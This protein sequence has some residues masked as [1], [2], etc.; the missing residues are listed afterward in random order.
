[1]A[2]IGTYLG[3]T[4]VRKFRKNPTIHPPKSM[5]LAMRERSTKAK[6]GRVRFFHIPDGKMAT[7]QPIIEANVQQFPERIIT[8]LSAVYEIMFRNAKHFA[9]RTVNHSREWIVPGTRFHTN[10]MESS[11]SLLKKR[12]LIGSFHRVSVKHLHRYLTEFEYRFNARNAG[13]RF[14][15]ALSA[16]LHKPHMPYK[17]LIA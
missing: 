6:T 15:M 2:S 10:T 17:A 9:H 7:M 3:G 8:D 1:M 14:N 13:D 4:A 11:F 12:G 5:V 16:M